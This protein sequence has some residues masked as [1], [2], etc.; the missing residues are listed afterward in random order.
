MQLDLKT[1]GIAT[2]GQILLGPTGLVPDGISIDSRTVSDGQVFVAIVGERHDGHEH[3]AQA[4]ERGA[5]GCVVSREE[6][7]GVVPEG[8][9][10]LLVPDTTRF[11]GDLAA[12]L[13]RQSAAVFLGITGSVGKTTT[14]DLTALLIGSE[15]RTHA[16]KGNLNNHF[17]LPLSLF[18]LS[19]DAQAC[20]LEMGISTPGELDRLVEIAEPDYGLVT[21]I[22]H[23]HVGNFAGFDEL[24]VEKLKLPRGARRAV[25]CVDDPEQ[26]SRI[27]EFEQPFL[28]GTTEHL[29]SGPDRLRL[30]ERRP[31][32]F[33]GQDVVL[34]RDGE[35][36]EIFLPLVGEHQA[37]NLL[38]AAS[39]A[40]LVGISRQGMAEAALK[41]RPAAHRGTQHAVRGAVL[42]DD[43]YN[44]NPKAMQAALE[45]M[46]QLEPE[47]RRILIAGDMLELGELS[48]SAHGELGRQ[49]A[50]AGL[51]VLVGVG[52]ECA[53]AVEAAREAGLSAEHRDDATA[54]GEWLV[55]NVQA[56]D[57]VVVKGSRGIGLDRSVELFVGEAS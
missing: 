33:E 1:I 4:F 57:L 34:E 17:G 29:D 37:R 23:A 28:F 47:G 50:A 10:C 3:L 43:S 48:E 26:R 42:L 35:R 56:G 14:K 19:D 6:A 2:R 16:S 40:E 20:V 49:A 11:L 25:L 54:A 18:G 41:A 7:K 8:R 51:D 13:R 24:V 27:D 9:A 39:L 31:R 15:R 53:H 36:F 55:E 46:G 22:H 12:H 21:G 45:L 30:L 32:G 52:P 44:A 5:A 38:A